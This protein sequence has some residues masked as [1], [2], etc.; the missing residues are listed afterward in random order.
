MSIKVTLSQK[1]ISKGTKKSLY[2]DFSPG[3]P[4]KFHPVS[5]NPLRREFLNMYLFVNEKDPANKLHNKETWRLA[6][7][8]EAQR[9]NEVN[10]PEIY[11]DH[12]KEVLRIKGLGAVSFTDYFKSLADKRTGGTK[13]GWES[14]IKYF[15]DFTG[16]QLLFADL[17]ESLCNRFR[18]YL[19]TG[20][21]ARTNKERIANNTA[22]VYFSKF[23]SALRHAYKDGYL[24]KDLNIKI[25]PIKTEETSRN[26]LTLDEVNKLI[27]T[28]CALPVMKKAAIFSV[29]T[30]LRFSDIRNLKW[31]QVTSKEGEGCFISFKQQKTKGIE[32]LPISEDAFNLMGQRMGENDQVFAGLHYSPYN[33]ALLQK[34]I[35]LAGITKDITF[36]CFRHTFAT[37]QLTMGTDIYT[38]SKLLGHRD[39]KTTQIY[40][41]IVD[42]TKRTAA[43]RIQLN[44]TNWK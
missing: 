26:F 38:V 7:I 40:A 8:C 2:L 12:E 24:Q 14:A 10:K 29:Y 5:G 25:D 42:A 32:I 35:G 18:E 15:G 43:N 22:W 41:K 44:I 23:K 30:G 31:G 19:Q 39:L 33:N 17:N 34:W 27:Q 20:T 9:S 36:H 37:M 3:I 11:A 13:E 28:E 1:P 4:G 6:R 21:G 16:G